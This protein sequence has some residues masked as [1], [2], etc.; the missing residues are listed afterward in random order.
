MPIDKD[1]IPQAGETVYLKGDKKCVAMY[2][3]RVY[4]KGKREVAFCTWT[5]Y[6]MFNDELFSH[7][8]EKEIYLEKLTVFAQEAGG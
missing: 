6:E 1:R 5:E 8:R 2:L 4:R 7:A 3:E